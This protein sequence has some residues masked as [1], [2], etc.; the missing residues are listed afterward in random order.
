MAA[1]QSRHE[2]GDARMAFD[3]D[4]RILAA[5]IDHVQDIGAYPTP[6]PVGTAAAV[7]MLFPGP[8]RVPAAGWR[9]TSVFSNTSGRDGLPRAVAVR[10]ARPRGAA[11][12]RGPA[13]GHRP[14]RAAPPQPAAPG[15]AAVRA[16]RTGCPTT[17][18][19]RS[20]PSSRRWRCSTSTPSVASR[21]RRARPGRY[22]GVGT[23]HLRRADHDRAGVLRHRGR[24]DPHRAVG[25]GQRL[26]RRRL[27]RQQPRDD[28]RAAHRGCPR[29]RHRRRPHDP[30]RHRGDPVRGRAPAA[31]G[32]AR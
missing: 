30:G 22:L 12:H 3:D 5:H 6:W 11:R 26:R 16:T 31:A 25:Q 9:S 13:H 20:R 21:P 10:V 1:G 19:P 29:R 15:R 8:Y 18:S 14:D 28:R 27:D 17:T 7:G 23:S 2:H 32:A 24:H 4:G